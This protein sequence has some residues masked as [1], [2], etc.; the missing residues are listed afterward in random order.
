MPPEAF[1][2]MW[3]ISLRE[4]KGQF[5][6]R[7]N[8]ARIPIFWPR[9]SSESS[10]P[11]PSPPAAGR[12]NNFPTSQGIAQKIEFLYLVSRTNI[13]LLLQRNVSESGQ[14]NSFYFV[15]ELHSIHY[16]RWCS[17]NDVMETSSTWFPEQDPSVF[18]R[19]LWHD[20][21]NP[22]YLIPRE[23][24]TTFLQECQENEA[25]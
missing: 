13:W 6:W 20:I 19:H 23:R 10:H 12:R 21:V 14:W 17:W 2:R 8:F 15:P 11:P 9:Q 7:R 22:R 5:R 4:Y 24:F 25:T 18:E 16:A 1:S 3:E